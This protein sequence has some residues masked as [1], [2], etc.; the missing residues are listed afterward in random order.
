MELLFDT[1][2]NLKQKECVQAWIDNTV[3]E[4]TYGGSK[5][6]AKSFTGCSLIFGDAFIYP[7][8]HYFIARKNLNDIR[9]FTIPSIHE[10]LQLWKVGQEYFKYNGQDNFFELYNKSKVFLLDAKYLP[11][12]PHFYRFG[13]MQMTRG[14]IE[15]AGEFTLEAKN[16]LQASIGRWKNDLYGIN[17]KL[18]QTCNPSKNYL[19]RDVYKPFKE[20]TLDHWKRFIQALPTDNKM[21]SKEYLLNLERILSRNEKQRLL[22]GNWEY[23]DNPNALCEYDS[24][25][26]IFTNDQIKP[27][28]KKFI[29]ADVARFGSDKAIIVVWNDWTVIE[30]H[31]FDKS[32]TTQIQD[33]INALRMKHVIPKNQVIADEDGVGGGVVDN[34]GIKGF[35]NNSSPIDEGL[36]DKP[37]FQNLQAQCVVYFANRVNANGIHFAAELSDKHKEEI[38]EEIETIQSYKTDLDGK[39]KIIPKEKVKELIG[40]SPDWRDV[41]MMREYFELKPFG[42]GVRS[43]V[44]RRN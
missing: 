3:T 44:T 38:I 6:S 35:V 15:E 29:T 9:K 19:Y 17:G 12:D 20:G 22:L 36:K 33:C 25:L 5:G 32:R 1:K 13:S 16:N 42:S 10:V 31:V 37:N 4:I 41:L 11:S 8:T 18:L 14:W 43:H 23:D 28:G 34:C 21:L 24:I 39:V 27:S 26:A 2:D 40:R 7:E 30:Y